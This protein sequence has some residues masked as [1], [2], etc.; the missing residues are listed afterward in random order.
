MN[1]E[2][3][4]IKSLRRTLFVIYVVLFRPFLW[5][6]IWLIGRTGLIKTIFLIYPTDKREFADLCPDFEWFLKFLSGRPTPGGLI[7]D[8]GKPVGIYLYI[9]NTPQELIKKKNRLLAEA[10]VQRMQWIQKIS[11]A[12]ACGFAGQLGPL[13]EKRHNI[14]MQP[15][16][17]SSTM[18]N[19]FSID[20]AISFLARTMKKRPW[21]ISIAVLGG[22]DLGG[23][24]QTHFAEQGYKVNIVDLLF[25]RRGGGVKIKDMETASQQLDGADF[26]INLL[27]TGEDFLRC[28]APYFLK[29]S[30]VVIDFSRPAIP[31]QKLPAKVFMG[32]RVQRNGSRFAFALPGWRQQELPACSLPSILAAN[33]GIVEQ[34]MAKFC[35]AARRVAFETA[36]AAA[37][38]PAPRPLL[39]R[40]HLL[41]N[42][43][44]L[45]CRFYLFIAKK[46]LRYTIGK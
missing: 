20:D 41:G 31:Q 13:L 36:L 8:Q 1:K 11:G 45:N 9:S 35:A 33:Y 12:T 10:I 32:N 7:I 6:I 30:T 34:D 16:F 23:K 14:P 5:A 4:M 37:V 19:I 29:E 25:K 42:E 43:F 40:L 46:N 44:M 24:L 2:K 28:G 26:V 3:K 22:G 18:G 27:P 21:Q 39:T 17:F 15:P 38:P